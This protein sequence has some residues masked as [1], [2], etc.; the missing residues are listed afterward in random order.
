MSAR[1]TGAAGRRPEP[2]RRVAVIRGPIPAE[3]A[4]SIIWIIIIGFLAGVIARLL[5]PDRTTRP[6]SS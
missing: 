1:S 4:L 2:E 3:G 6:A 5:S